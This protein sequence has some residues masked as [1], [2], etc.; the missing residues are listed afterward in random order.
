MIVSSGS[1]DWAQFA[2]EE[3]LAEQAAW[4]AS[5]GDFIQRSV[6]AGAELVAYQAA[7][8]VLAQTRQTQINAA[9]VIRTT[10][11]LNA[12]ETRWTDE[13]NARHT[14]TL[15][16]LTPATTYV[17]AMADAEEVLA[18]S[19]ATATK[20]LALGESGGNSYGQEDY[21]ADMETA[22]GTHYASRTIARDDYAS[23]YANQTQIYNNTLAGSNVTWVSE[24][25][26]ADVAF[27]TAVEN[28]WYDFRV[29]DG[30]EYKTYQ[31]DLATDDFNY[32]AKLTT[33]RSSAYSTQFGG[34][35]D[36]RE[37][38][39]LD[40]VS[41]DA[42]FSGSMNTA[43]QTLDNKLASEEKIQSDSEA[44]AVRDVNT[45]LAQKD[46][47]RNNDQAVAEQSC[48]TSAG[49]ALADKADAGLL[50]LELP[51]VPVPGDLYLPT[52]GTLRGLD[53]FAGAAGA[54]QNA[55]NEM[56]TVDAFDDGDIEGTLGYQENA[57][58]LK[59]STVG[60][61][62]LRQRDQDGRV[63]GD[64]EFQFQQESEDLFQQDPDAVPVTEGGGLPSAAAGDLGDP[65][66][67][68]PVV[69]KNSVELK[70]DDEMS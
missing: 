18:G 28:A 25:A 3:A 31:D 9:D 32:R 41:A 33:D 47:T 35:P 8:G 6:D 45:G 40:R 70:S 37:Q 7:S 67:I 20:Y 38:L 24:M 21:D 14:Y 61:N 66:K 64:G 39:A 55:A 23:D 22:R 13:V 46:A 11:V 59:G 44:G 68:E 29:N 34:N 65:G 10:A 5:K 19:D 53:L 4:T 17:D 50:K 49:Q 36:P 54:T 43:R 2:Y 58:R 30:A 60:G 57:D 42:T 27:V 16:V 12:D 52:V 51:T 63:V 26:L 1:A 15:G 48:V 69:A 56:F 62:Q